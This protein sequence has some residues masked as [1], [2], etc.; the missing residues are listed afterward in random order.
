MN[1]KYLI[2]ESIFNY[3]QTNQKT[4]KM[5]TKKQETI[6]ALTRQSSVPDALQA[7][8]D[9]IAAMKHIQECVYLTSGKITTGSGGQ[10]DIKEEKN[11]TELVKAFSGILFRAKAIEEAYDELGI[12][13]YPAVK[14]DGGTVEEWKKDILLR[15]EI[16]NQKD[17]LDELNSL[18]KEWEDLMDKEDKKAMLVKKME[19]FANG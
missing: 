14:V 18:K 12:N 6:T 13:S 19:K 3:K 7:I 10:K 11:V 4:N 15:I 8:N 1:L 9:R 16:I 2:K 5:A 17:T